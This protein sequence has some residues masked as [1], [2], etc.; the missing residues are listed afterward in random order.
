METALRRVYILTANGDIEERLY[1][2]ENELLEL[3]SLYE[4]FYRLEDACDARARE[5][6]RRGL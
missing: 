3:F 1:R 5:L 4:V 6:A 2:T